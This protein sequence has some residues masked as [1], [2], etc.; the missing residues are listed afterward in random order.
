MAL[1]MGKYCK[2]RFE[3]HRAFWGYRKL[4]EAFVALYSTWMSSTMFVA[5]KL[6]ELYSI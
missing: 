5:V 1:M 3:R 2:K 6:G 4:P